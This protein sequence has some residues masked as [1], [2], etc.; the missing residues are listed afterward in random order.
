MIHYIEGPIIRVGFEG[1]GEHQIFQK[2]AIN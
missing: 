1:E 2:S